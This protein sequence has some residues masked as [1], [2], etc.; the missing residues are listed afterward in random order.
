MYQ[1]QHC[2]FYAQMPFGGALVT[3]AAHYDKDNGDGTHRLFVRLDDGSEIP[4]EGPQ[5]DPAT[6]T[7]G[8]WSEI[9]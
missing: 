5:C 9:A 3:R 1:G 6:P 2:L 4:L 7:A 8:H